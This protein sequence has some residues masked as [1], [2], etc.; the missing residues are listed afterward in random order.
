MEVID[1]WIMTEEGV[2]TDMAT[3]D[4]AYT[5]KLASAEFFVLVPVP[6]FLSVSAWAND[7]HSHSHPLINTHL[8]PFTRSCFPCLADTPTPASYRWGGGDC[9]T[10]TYHVVWV[11]LTWTA[12]SQL[13]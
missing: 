12:L 7:N 2:V 9:C 6:V 13:L 8:M 3:R 10:T 4:A 5:V 1:T 11:V